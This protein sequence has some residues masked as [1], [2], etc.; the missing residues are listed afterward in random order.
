MVHLLRLGDDL[1]CGAHVALPAGLQSLTF[2]DHFDQ[3]M[4]NVALPAGLQSLT[5]DGKF[6]QSMDKVAL[7]SGL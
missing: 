2:G 1:A 4:E 3:S 7:P 6:N 5:F